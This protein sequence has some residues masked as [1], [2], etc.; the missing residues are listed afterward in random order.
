MCLE[1][2]QRRRIKQRSICI[3]G[4]VHDKINALLIWWSDWDGGCICTCAC[5]YYILLSTCRRTCMHKHTCKCNPPS[6]S[7]HQI[8]KAFILSWMNEINALFNPQAL[9]TSLVHVLFLAFSVLPLRLPAGRS[10]LPHMQA[11]QPMCLI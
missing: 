8:S 11:Y 6:Q 7:D 2:Y 3:H 4:Y 5:T 10:L 9:D 1:M